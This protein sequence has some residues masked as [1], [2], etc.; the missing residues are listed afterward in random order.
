[1][2]YCFFILVFIYSIQ[3]FPQKE[4]RSP[5]KILS[6][7]QAIEAATDSSLVA[8]KAR[9]LYLSGYWQFKTFKAERLPSLTL[10]M[11]PFQY[12]RNIV[13]RYDSQNDVDIY[14]SQ[15]S[16]YS[17]ANLT[18]KQN[19]DLTGGRFF[20]D[21]ELGYLKNFGLSTRE[22]YSSVPVRI[23]YSQSLFGYNSLK[24]E[25][26][27]EPVRYEKVKKELLY[28]LEEIAEQTSEYYFDLALSQTL[29]DLARQ[30]LVNSDTLYRIGQERY[31]IGSISQSD[32]L[33]LKLNLLNSRNDISDAGISLKKSSFTL[34]AHLRYDTEAT[35]QLALPT[36]PLGVFIPAGE[37]L[38]YAKL[39][40]PAVP[41]LKESILS[42]QQSLEKTQRE[43]R[44]SA[45]LS[46]SVGFN[47]VATSLSDA[48]RRPLQQDVVSVSLSVP[49]LDWGVRRGKVNMARNNLNVVNISAKQT[50]QT[51][52]Q[53]VLMTVNE[54]NE[55]QT[56]IQSAEEVKQI[57]ELAYEKT[58]QLFVIGKTNVD[59]VNQALSRRIQAESNYIAALKSYWLSYY[60]LRKLTLYDFVAGKTISAEYERGEGF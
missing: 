55:R 48:Y 44:F 58:K 49:I 38:R 16:L 4:Q 60:K 37:A 56:R 42:A 54:Y 9:N 13:K 18:L 43:S 31:K 30:N 59:G 51:L 39:N 52:E 41:E 47:Q 8:F 1:M 2:K 23:G 19:V 57:A 26:R 40:N 25:K 14:K 7:D 50:E 15:Q 46:A 24:W 29:Y 17:S 36:R 27:I 11:S 20:I 12:N 21:T 6:L 10:D 5:I 3:S 32:L 28:N 35:F 22:Q 53:E 33:T 45:S 34:A